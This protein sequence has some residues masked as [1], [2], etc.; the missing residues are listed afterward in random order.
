MDGGSSADAGCTALALNGLG[1]ID[2][3]SAGQM[4]TASIS[5]NAS[6]CAALITITSGTGQC[7]GVARPPYDGFD[8]GCGGFPACTSTTLPGTINCG[9]CSILIC[10]GGSCP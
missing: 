3:C 10:D 4:A 7:T 5:V 6:T 2:G 9:F 8:G 1:V